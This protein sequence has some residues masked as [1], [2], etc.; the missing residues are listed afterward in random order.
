LLRGLYFKGNNISPTL[1]T[2]EKKK[3]QGKKIRTEN[4]KIKGLKGK[5]AR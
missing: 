2:L 3:F 5:R 1:P 4:E